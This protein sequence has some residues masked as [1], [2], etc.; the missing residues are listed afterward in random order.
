[1]EVRTQARLAPYTSFYIGG[2]ADTLV[3]AESTEDL[4]LALQTA[5]AQ[6]QPITILGGGSN[7]LIADSGIRGTVIRLEN[8]GINICHENDNEV[9][10]EVAAGEL[11]DDVVRLA[12]E[13]GW[14][15]IENLSHIPGT[16]GAFPVQNV[17]AY[18]QEASQVIT[19]VQVLDRTTHQLSTLSAEQLKF[20]YRSSIF[21]QSQSGQYIVVS[22]TMKLSKIPRPNL[23]YRDLQERFPSDAQ[24][25]LT[26]IRQA[27]IEIRNEKYP[28]PDKPDR[29]SAGSFFRGPLL[30]ETEFTT[31]QTR[32]A[33]SINISSGKRL[34]GMADKLRVAQGFKT[35]AA[36]LLELAGAKGLTAGGAMINPEQPAVILN[37]TG[38]ATADDVIR[39]YQ[40]AR[41]LVRSN[42]GVMLS[43]EPEFL[44]FH[45]AVK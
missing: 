8:Y 33:Q 6:S 38:T 18:G 41:E 31:L 35:P 36:Y 16:M 27:I 28:Y 12:T 21:N 34:M 24:P 7:V 20:G 43:H 39:L 40:Q 17:G 3:F 1:M 11:W 15:G 14:W 9:I 22:C 23:Q 30:S 44:G 26:Q 5:E 13:A 45:E 25:T 29:G 10:L 19:C 2:P 37:Y 32:I 4:I 42:T